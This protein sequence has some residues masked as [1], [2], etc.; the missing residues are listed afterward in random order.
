MQDTSMVLPPSSGT[1]ELYCVGCA[2]L[3]EDDDSANESFLRNDYL[4]KN[5]DHSGME[6]LA[7][8][9]ADCIVTDEESDSVKMAPPTSCP[10]KVNPPPPANPLN[11]LLALANK[12]ME[13][14]AQS[15]LEEHCSRV[16]DNSNGQTPSRSPGRHSPK[17]W[18][19]D[20]NNSLRYPYAPGPSPNVSASTLFPA[21]NKSHLRRKDKDASALMTASSYDSGMGTDDKSGVYLRDSDMHHKYVYHHHHHHHHMMKDAAKSRVPDPEV[22]SRSLQYQLSAPAMPNFSESYGSHRTYHMYNHNVWDEQSRTPRPKDSKRSGTRKGVDSNSNIDSGVGIPC[23]A[24]TVPN[25]HDPAN[26]KVLAWM[27][28]NDKLSTGNTQ[29]STDGSDK[30]SSHKRSSHRSSST[31]Q[32]KSGSGSGK[33]SQ[34]QYNNSSRSGSLD[35]SGFNSFHQPVGGDYSWS[36]ET[37][38][39]P[40]Q[41]FVQDTS[42]PLLNPPNSMT[43][44]EEVRRRLEDE[45]LRARIKQSKS[46]TGTSSRDRRCMPP[47]PTHPPR[48]ASSGFS[49]NTPQVAPLDLSSSEEHSSSLGSQKSESRRSAKKS[50]SAPTT[51]GQQSEVTVIG[52]YFCN[53]PIPYRTSLPGKNITLGQFKQLISK[54]GNYR[55]FFKTPSDEFDSGVVHEEIHLDHQILPLWEGKIVGK[56]ERKE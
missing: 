42:M 38:V 53:E 43:Q 22:L 16:W 7:M 5:A 40:S 37:A 14:N 47:P 51:P 6:N 28:E 44:L 50:S 24:N 2:W 13:D 33:K 19:H 18:S 8:V 49:K 39:Q 35:R 15:I 46:F 56:V 1:L 30:A 48:S 55:Y 10:P 23:D 54:K 27:L 29:Y 36:V 41:P 20:P 25:L 11:V 52:Y 31:S 17:S 45:S 4:S 34:S 32:H 9:R 3:G 21:H 12:D 26:E